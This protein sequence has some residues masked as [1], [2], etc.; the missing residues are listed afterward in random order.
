MTKTTRR[1]PVRAAALLCLAGALVTGC[2]G[3]ADGGGGDG[4]PDAAGQAALAADA[5]PDKV[6]IAENVKSALEVRISTGE[7]RFGSGTNSPCATS[8]PRVFTEEC[9]EAADYTREA[10]RFALDEID[11]RSGFATLGNAA[12]KLDKAAAAYRDLGCAKAPSA[13]AARKACLDP[14]AVVAQGFP[15]LRSGANKGLAGK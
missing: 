5:V 12:R 3:G 2:S 13:A 15:D 7:G 1:F 14:A 10:A 8:S 6:R 9:G 11:G 4:R